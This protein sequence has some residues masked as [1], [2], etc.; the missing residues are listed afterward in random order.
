MNARI[1]E[2]DQLAL[3]PPPQHAGHQRSPHAHREGEDGRDHQQKARQWSHV[4][5]HRNR[6]QRG[7][8]PRPEAKTFPSTS[9]PLKTSFS[10]WE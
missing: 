10:M 7:S 4:L 3:V 5:L 1:D 9:I 8:T 6:F 2:I